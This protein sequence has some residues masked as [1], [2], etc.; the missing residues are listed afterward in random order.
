MHSS[1]ISLV[2]VCLF[3]IMSKWSLKPQGFSIL[4]KI[5]LYTWGLDQLDKTVCP[6]IHLSYD[7]IIKITQC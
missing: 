4:F 3:V 6:L 7:F 2:W 1:L 5:K